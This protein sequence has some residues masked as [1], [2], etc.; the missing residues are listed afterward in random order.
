MKR[1]ELMA[2]VGK[3]VRVTFLDGKVEEGT[4]AY[5]SDFSPKH[6]YTKPGYFYFK[7]CRREYDI[8]FKVSHT[9][10]VEVL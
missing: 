3:K 4:L 9:K 6:R 2:L 8:T 7:E 5:A 10:K 1:D